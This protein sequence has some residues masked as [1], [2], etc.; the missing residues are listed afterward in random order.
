MLYDPC[1][2]P[3]M[4]KKLRSLVTSCLRRHV[5]TASNQLRKDRPLALV[6]WGCRLSMNFV[7]ATQVIS[8]IRE[9]AVRGPE[10]RVS[11]DGQYDLGLLKRASIV[12][13]S[14]EED[15]NICP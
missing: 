3:A 2:H 15:T 7:E 13:G 11:Q 14:D 5:I 6:A 4:V 1:A 8:F 10:G 9:K 12:E